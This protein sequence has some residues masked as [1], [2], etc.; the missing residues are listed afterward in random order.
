MVHYFENILTTTNVD[1]IIKYE[2]T[3]NEDYHKK[4]RYVENTS[5]GE[6]QG[7]KILLYHNPASCKAAHTIE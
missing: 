6:V 2:Q 7:I 3:T 4:N 5:F 1:Y